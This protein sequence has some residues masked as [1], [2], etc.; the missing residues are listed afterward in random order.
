MRS[1]GQGSGGEIRIKCG[2]SYWFGDKNDTFSFVGG[3]VRSVEV[4][5][6]I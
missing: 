3:L 2:T 4:S 5:R 6:S 1:L